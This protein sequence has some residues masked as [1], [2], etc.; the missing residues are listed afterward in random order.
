VSGDASFEAKGT[1]VSIIVLATNKDLRRVPPAWRVSANV[2]VSLALVAVGILTA[3]GLLI[4]LGVAAVLG[5]SCEVLAPLHD[6]R[7]PLRGY[8]TD[9]T[10]AIGNRCLI[11][12]LVAVVVSLIGPV[13]ARA[14]PLAAREG[15]ATLPWL[16]QVIVALVVTDFTNYLAHY[17]LHHSRVLWSF[18][19]IHHSSE[20]LDW[21]ATSRGHPLD[22]AFNM[23]AITLPTYAMGQIQMAPWLLTFFFLYPFVCHA[24][25]RIRFAWVGRILV[26]PEFHHWHHAADTKAYDK[27]FGA[28]LS[29]WD[30]LFGT[31]IEPG[32]FPDSYGIENPAL[33]A[34]DY[35]GQIAA[36]FRTNPQ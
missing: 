27:N 25:A 36:P 6:S 28:F 34:T 16:V 14:V 35:L 7:R 1:D 33:D 13:V 31:A 23:V 8:A 29:I 9:L 10:H 17:G 19:A 21:L 24:N 26:T 5:A 2:V 11:V 3:P 22:L 15:L 20:Q 18:H 30:R 12:P 32:Q 4:S